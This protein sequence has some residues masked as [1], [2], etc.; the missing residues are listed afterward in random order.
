MELTSREL[1]LLTMPND[2]QQKNN[3]DV[4]INI[5]GNL[6]IYIYIFDKQRESRLPLTYKK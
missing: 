5:L 1:E 2:A 6:K 3:I 4:S